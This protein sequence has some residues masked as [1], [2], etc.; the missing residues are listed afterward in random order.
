MSSKDYIAPNFIGIGMERAGT[1]WLFT[2]IAA[3]PE[4][5]VP[6]LKELHFFDVI[7]PRAKYL[8]HRYSYHLKSRIKQ[9]A[10]PFL[11]T[12]TRP[13]FSKNSY[14]EYLRW[15]IAYFKGTFDVGWYRGLF[16]PRFTKGRVC[17]EITPAY[18]NLTPETIAQILSL[19]PDMKFILVVRNPIQRMWSGIVHHFRHVERRD[20]ENVREEEMLNFLTHSAAQNRSDLASILET[21][22]GNVPAENLFIQPFEDIASAPEALINDVYNF[23]GVDHTF[24]PDEALYKRRINAYTKKNYDMLPRVK[25]RLLE[26]SR[27]GIDLLH[28]THPE[29]TKRWENV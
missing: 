12:S 17:G 15:D 7:D 28:K 11:D 1:S 5:W 14:L 6:P 27:H 2:Q 9:K 4:I 25:E 16:H 22:Q 19:N 3:H 10:A 29:I 20:F 21:W 24:L 8:T 26:A 18:S 13:E 23:L